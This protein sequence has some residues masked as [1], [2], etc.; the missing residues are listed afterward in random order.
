MTLRSRKRF[1]RLALLPY[2][3]GFNGAVT[4]R[5][6]KLKVIVMVGFAAGASMGP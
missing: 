3:P 2:F 6:R 1:A 4:L 5:S